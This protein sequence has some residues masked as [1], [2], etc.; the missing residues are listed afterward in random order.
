MKTRFQCDRRT[1]LAWGLGASLLL[2]LRQARASETAVAY[3]R[4]DGIGA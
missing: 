2:A 4:I 3:L 1:F